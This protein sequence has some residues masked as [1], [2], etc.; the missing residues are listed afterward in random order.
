MRRLPEHTTVTSVLRHTTASE[1]VPHGE[2]GEIASTPSIRTTGDN[3]YMMRLLLLFVSKSFY[4]S[5][6]FV[7]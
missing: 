6:V 2:G 4:D 1:L 3:Q 7:L 5:A